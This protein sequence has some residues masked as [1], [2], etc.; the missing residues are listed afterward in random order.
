MEFDGSTEF[1]ISTEFD[2]STDATSSKISSTS[3]PWTKQIVGKTPMEQIVGKTPMEQIV[4][5][6]PMELQENKEYELN[7]EFPETLIIHNSFELLF[8]NKF[9]AT[10]YAEYTLIFKKGA[11]CIYL[12][13]V[14]LV[15]S[16]YETF[17]YGCHP[18]DLGWYLHGFSDGISDG[19]LKDEK[20]P[21]KFLDWNNNYIEVEPFLTDGND[22]VT[23]RTDLTSKKLNLYMGII[24]SGPF[25]EQ[26]D[27]SLTFRADLKRGQLSI[28]YLVLLI[29]LL[30][31]VACIF[32]CLFCCKRRIKKC[33]GKIFV[34]FCESCI[35]D[36]T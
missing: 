33:G 25:L 11:P 26:E 30:I 19:F 34:D 18:L 1:E 23:I 7:V 8:S 20:T 13:D 12:S 32:L 16:P 15:D 31:A 21:Q 14:P 36:D 28:S 4:G 27:I 35:Q 17:V 9:I 6:L 29:C 2:N 5:K 22:G 3:G 24:S 10:K